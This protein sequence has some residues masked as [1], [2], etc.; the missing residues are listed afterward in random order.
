M[1]VSQT[2]NSATSTNAK[3]SIRKPDQRRIF[4]RSLSKKVYCSNDLTTGLR[5]RNVDA[6]INQRYIQHNH[7]NS[8]L[9]LVYDIDRPTCVDEITDDLDLP[10]PHFFVQNPKNN[11]A[12]LYY[13]LETPVHLNQ[14]SSQKA[15]RFAG[16]VD[17][18]MTNS[19]QADS[20]YAG[21]VA[22]NP[23]HEH[24]RTYTI[25]SEMFSL[26]DLSEY[27]DLTQYGDKRKSFP[28]VGIGRNVNLFERLR[29]WSYKA[30]RQ[31]WPDL[32]QWDRACFDR[33]LAYNSTENPLPLSEVKATARSVA[34][35]THKNMSPEGFSQL[36]AARGALKGQSN[37]DANLQAVVEMSLQGH[38]QRVIADTLG[39]SKSSV[40]RWLKLEQ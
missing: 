10:A 17:C 31:G 12:H 6:A 27:L 24:W 11:H 5:I 16:A 40:D 19:M 9:W 34:K 8:R 23:L 21:L 18:A 25:N 1:I 22:K 14:N 29:R 4:K 38:S 33:A 7:K 32:D 30:I 26:G 28:D 13:G 39:L 15:I 2:L 37:R 20:Q 3:F 36:Q 35:W